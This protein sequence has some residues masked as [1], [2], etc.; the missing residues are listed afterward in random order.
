MEECPHPNVRML[1][2]HCWV[3]PDC[4]AE[5]CGDPPTSHLLLDIDTGYVNM[6]GIFARLEDGF[7]NPVSSKERKKILEHMR[8]SEFEKPKRW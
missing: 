2:S 8:P 1:N 6:S 5:A 3:C 7:G 4:G